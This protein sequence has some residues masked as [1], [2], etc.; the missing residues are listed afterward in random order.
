MIEINLL[1]G[2]QKRKK[3]PLAGGLAQKLRG[4]MPAV[5]RLMAFVATAW[6]VALL[7]VGWM[8]FGVRSDRARLQ[9][10]LDQ[11]VADSARF[12]RLIEAQA[13]LQARQDTIAQKLTIIQE[14]DAGRYIW[15]HILDEI[16][17][18]MPPYTWLEAIDQRS[19]GSQPGFQIEGRTGSL[20]ALTRFMD[21]LEAS[22]F[23]RNVE[24]VR[25]EQAQISNDPPT[26]VN[27]FVLTGSYE[28]PAMEMIETVPLFVEGSLAP[29]VEVSDGAAGTS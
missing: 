7:A 21:A 9:A 23:L 25:S 28:L 14:I 26:V 3:S 18:A 5:D 6:I 20:P 2:G 19:G 27:N 16:S 24:L 8:F 10:G 15:P 1:P 29:E 12:A 4:S 11:A 13:S 17:R 22:P